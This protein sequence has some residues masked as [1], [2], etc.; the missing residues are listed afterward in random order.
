MVNPLTQRNSAAFRRRAQL[1]INQYL[2]AHQPQ[3][4]Y[5]TDNLWVTMR[6]QA[7]ETAAIGDFALKGRFGSELIGE[8]DVGNR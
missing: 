6:P 8:P 4:L 1:K 2:L 7:W 3:I 5:P